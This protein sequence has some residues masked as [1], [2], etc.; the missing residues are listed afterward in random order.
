M[1][2]IKV[3]IFDFDNT[4]VNSMG[5]DIKSIKELMK[6]LP[7]NVEFTEFMDSSVE[8]LMMF[9]NL[10]NNNL[11]NPINVHRYRIEETCKQFSVGWRAEY[12]KYYVKSYIE[13]TKCYPRVDN[14]LKYLHGKV[15]IGMLCNSYDPKVEMERIKKVNI[16]KYFDEII[17][18]SDIGYYK[19]SK[20]SFLYLVNKFDIEPSECIFIGDSEEFDI[21]GGRNAGLKTIKII[22]GAGKVGNSVAD[23]ICK[24]F[25]QLLRLLK[26]E[27]IEE[28]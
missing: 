13:N 12:Q 4:M 9:Y 16:D 6:L 25:Q 20:E 3:V 1:E 19:P 28:T 14:I 17:V 22:H 2:K 10:V 21:E 15:K 26:E 7:I 27:I 18:C 24:D 23:Y 5:A 11:E 8:K